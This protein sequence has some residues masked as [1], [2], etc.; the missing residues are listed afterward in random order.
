MKDS[1]SSIQVSNKNNDSGSSVYQ[2][3]FL[4]SHMRANTSLI[5][6]ILG[7]HPQISGYYEMHL[8]I[9]QKRT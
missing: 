5:S 7:S 1:D 2:H 8:V 4:L 6:H 3:I 9:A